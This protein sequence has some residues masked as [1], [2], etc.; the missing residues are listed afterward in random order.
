LFLQRTIRER[1][2]IEGIGLHTGK[3]A[4]L[5]FCPAPTGSGIHFVRRD[6]VDAPSLKVHADN[7]VSTNNATTLGNPAFSVSTVE[8]C[9]SAMSALRIDNLIIELDGPEIPIIDGSAK[10]YLDGLLKV[11]LVEQDEVRKYAYVQQP[12]YYGDDSKHAFVTPYD[13]LRITCVIEFPHPLVGKQQMDIDINVHSFQTQIAGARTF[14]FLK[15]VEYLH[16]KGLALGG[17]L[18]NAIV[19]DTEKI[20]NPE[21][22]RFPDEFVRHKVLDA[23]G[24]LTTLG[25]PLLGHLTLYKAGHDV[26]NKLINKILNTPESCRIME[27]AAPLDESDARF[28]FRWMRE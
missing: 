16:S 2:R 8:H 10:P 20:M 4:A 15:D 24:D 27:L 23:L 25:V 7:V 17:S 18:A 5:T 26:M 11:G 12:I 28:D 19:L 6:L 3:P 9:L 14:G 22:L 1:V 13:G 21:G